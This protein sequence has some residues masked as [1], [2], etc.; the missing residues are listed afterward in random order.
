MEAPVVLIDAEC[1]FCNRVAQVVLRNDASGR[2]RFAAL[3]SP[4][5]VRL[6]AA[7]GLSEPPTGTFVFLDE[8][9]AHVRSEGVVR[10]AAHL[11]SPWCGLSLFR[12]IPR[13]LRDVGYDIVARVRYRLLGR[14][15][16]CSLL[17]PEERARFLDDGV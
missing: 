7:R 17:S 3:G 16:P 9:G 10:L 15:A 2:I 8:S 12:W 1:L 14:I 6:L 5:A 4:A 13:P 11:R